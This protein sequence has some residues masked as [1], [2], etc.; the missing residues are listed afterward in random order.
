MSV[1]AK[2][3]LQLFLPFAISYL[4]TWTIWFTA[5]TAYLRDENGPTVLGKIKGYFS[6]LAILQNASDI[7]IETEK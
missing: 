7:F 2:A 3:F 6:S 1:S 4:A 5:P